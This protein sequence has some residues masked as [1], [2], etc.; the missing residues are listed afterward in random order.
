MKRVLFVCSGNVF[1]SASAKLSLD[2]YIKDNKIKGIVA[3][4]AGISYKPEQ[5]MHP[6]TKEMLSNFGIDGNRHVPKQLT[7]EVCDKSDI[8]IAMGVNHQDY[9]RENFRYKVPLFNEV[10]GQGKKPVLDVNE[11][12]GDDWAQKSEES[13][14]YLL[15]TTKYIHDMIPNIY[16]SIKN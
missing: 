13:Y 11:E 4:S 7:K 10:A 3:D 5:A 9:I 15:K 16:N 2:K 12:L 8:I 6:A 1:R 14:E